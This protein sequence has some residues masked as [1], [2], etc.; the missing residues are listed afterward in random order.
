[1]RRARLRSETVKAVLLWLIVAAALIAL[2][3]GVDNNYH[4][5]LLIGAGIS[6]IAVIPFGLLMGH[7][8][9]LA[10]G[11][12]GFV[13][14]GAYVVGNLTVH[15]FE[16]DFWAALPISIIVVGVLAYALSFPLFRLRGYHFAIGTLAVGQLLYL[17]FDNWEWLTGGPHGTIGIPRP[18]IGDFVFSTNSRFFILVAFFLFVAALASW[19][20]ARGSVGRALAAIRQDEDLAAARGLDVFRYKQFIFVYAA[21]FA[22]LAG[23][24]FGPMQIAI[25]PSSFTIWSSFQ[26]VIYV[27]IGG[28]GSL[29]GPAVGVVFIMILDQLIQDFGKWNQLVLGALIVLT[30]LFF[31]GGLWGGAALLARFVWQLVRGA[32]PPKGAAARAVQGRE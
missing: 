22:G 13:G 30:V 28:A 16:L 4:L 23:A 1:M 20:L 12:G 14:V 19:F 18:A 6:M 3:A 5:R 27:I 31:R 11:Q 21:V 25:D 2:W 10:M 15:Q 32:K 8:G 7:M 26:H 29:I 24:L 17:M 9:Y